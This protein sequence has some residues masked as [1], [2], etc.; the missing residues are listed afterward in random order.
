MKKM[1]LT[2]ISVFIIIISSV[3]VY[4]ITTDKSVDFDQT[5]DGEDVALTDVSNEIDGILLDED[6]EIDIGEMI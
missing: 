2:I 5:I 6:Y 4:H 3:L 1:F